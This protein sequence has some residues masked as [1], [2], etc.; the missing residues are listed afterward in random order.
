ML[1]PT[2]RVAFGED[3]FLLLMRSSFYKTL[4]KSYKFKFTR[5][6]IY[7]Q[8]LF[9]KK[10]KKLKLIDSLK[11]FNENVDLE[12]MQTQHEDD[13]KDVNLSMV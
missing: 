10:A 13:N 12:K 2:R 11:F 3:L 4:L 8:R 7:Q 6:N 5:M 1:N 9:K